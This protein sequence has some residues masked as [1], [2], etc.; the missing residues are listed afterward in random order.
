M[1]IPK[2]VKPHMSSTISA[3]TPDTTASEAPPSLSDTSIA[4]SAIP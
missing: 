2:T 1:C 4:P 3:T